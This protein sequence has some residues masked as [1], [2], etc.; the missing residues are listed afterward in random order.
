[1]NE[2]VIAIENR[3]IRCVKSER[4]VREGDRTVGRVIGRGIATRG[5]AGRIARARD[6]RDRRY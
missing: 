2:R 4:V 1:V 6:A 3:R 5:R